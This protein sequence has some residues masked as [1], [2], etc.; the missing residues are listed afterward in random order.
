MDFHFALFEYDVSKHKDEFLSLHKRFLKAR[1]ESW[2]LFKR[3]SGIYEL[4][5]EM[6]T[7]SFERTGFKEHGKELACDP[8]VF[9][10][11]YQKSEAVLKCTDAALSKL[12]TAMEPYLMFDERAGESFINFAQ[13][14]LTRICHSNK[15]WTK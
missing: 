15:H 13:S 8:D 9:L 14:A 4:L 10:G 2:F 7:R 3:E 6:H 12:K 5:G 11:S 1:E